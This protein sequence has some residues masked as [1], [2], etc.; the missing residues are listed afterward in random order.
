MLKLL[1]LILAALLA[2]VA[3]V[4]APV[5]GPK[6][7]PSPQFIYSAGYPAVAYASPY[8]YYG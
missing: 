1:F 4:P 6:P 2:L 8:V 7:D 3:A 5:A